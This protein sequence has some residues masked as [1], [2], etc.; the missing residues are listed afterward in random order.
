[1]LPRGPPPLQNVFLPQ[2]KSHSTRSRSSAEA[3]NRST[4]RAVGATRASH[5]VLNGTT[6]LNL[7]TFAAASQCLTLTV[8]EAILCES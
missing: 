1:M 3:T 6:L 8:P 7:D 5:L 4:R 2:Q